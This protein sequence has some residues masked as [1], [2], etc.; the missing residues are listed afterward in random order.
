[1]TRESE[2]KRSQRV[3][4]ALSVTIETDQGTIEGTTLDISGTGAFIC[5]QQSLQ[6]KEKVWIY[7]PDSEQPNGALRI[8]AEVVRPDILCVEYP[9]MSFGIG[10]EFIMVPDEAQQFLTSLLSNKVDAGSGQ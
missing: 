1:M 3:T 9:E 10:V 5:C 2:E 7:L 6:R 8:F 4:V